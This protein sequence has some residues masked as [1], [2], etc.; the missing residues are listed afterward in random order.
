MTPLE[1]IA[2]IFAAIT[3]MKFIIIGKNPKVLIKT[4]EGMA[5]KT[6]FLTIC[7]LAIFVVVGYYVFSTINVV[8]IF[9][10]M[11]LGVM[12]IGIMLVMYPKV[13]LSLAKNILKERQKLWL[14]MLIW[15]FLAGWTLYAIFV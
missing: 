8:D 15:A 13:Y 4:A 14:L 11:M 12:L 2:V 9:V 1:I 7:L 5:K 6:T 3:L 10:T